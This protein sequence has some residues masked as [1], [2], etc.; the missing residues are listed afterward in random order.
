M[1]YAVYQPNMIN[2]NKEFLITLRNVH[3]KLAM[4]C[5][6]DL[7]QY[8]KHSINRDVPDYVNKTMRQKKIDLDLHTEV[9]RLLVLMTGET[10]TNE[11]ITQLFNSV[12]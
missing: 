10:P 2:T 12:N 9:V 6:R 5:D 1:T 4:I 11:I 8:T 3:I 7:A